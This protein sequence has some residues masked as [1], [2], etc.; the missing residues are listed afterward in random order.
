MLEVAVI[1]H[2]STLTLRIYPTIS[3]DLPVSVGDFRVSGYSFELKFKSPTPA[4][5]VVLSQL[6]AI[7]CMRNNVN[8]M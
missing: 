5:T 4:A 6:R 7:I 1:Y 3:G 2:I 8:T